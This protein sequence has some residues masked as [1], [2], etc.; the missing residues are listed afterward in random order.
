[1][2]A[3]KSS[4]G[5]A[6]PC[7][8]SVAWCNSSSPAGPFAGPGSSGSAGFGPGGPAARPA[9]QPRWLRIEALVPTSPSSCTPQ[10]GQAS[11]PAGGLDVGASEE[12][13]GLSPDLG[14]G[15]VAGDDAHR[16]KSGPGAVAGPGVDPVVD[17]AAVDPCQAVG[18]GLRAFRCRSPR[19]NPCTSSCPITGQ[20]VTSTSSRGRR[21]WP[22]GRPLTLGVTSAAAPDGS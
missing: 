9:S 14:G 13:Q 3:T 19:D 4:I 6:E 1:M 20:A 11:G 16:A 10:G 2:T 7:I 15:R 8:A 18:A 21:A 22:A 17:G 5:T 12:E